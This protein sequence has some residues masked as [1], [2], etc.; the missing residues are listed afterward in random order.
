MAFPCR[1]AAA[2]P[3]AHLADSDD[4][5]LGDFVSE[6]VKHVHAVS[7]DN[8]EVHLS[9]LPNVSVGGL[10]S[11][12]WSARPGGFGNSELVNAWEEERREAVRHGSDSGGGAMIRCK[13]CFGAV[14]VLTA[15]QYL[16]IL[17]NIQRHHVVRF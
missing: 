17:K 10:D 5:L 2:P 16:K 9:V 15:P 7:A 13:V 6:D 1:P 3:P 8:S 4:S 14:V 12:D 11:P